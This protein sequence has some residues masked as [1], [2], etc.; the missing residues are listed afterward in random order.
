MGLCTAFEEEEYTV[1]GLMF[2]FHDLKRKYNF[3]KNV[4]FILVEFFCHLTFG[5][6]L[7][8]YHFA[9]EVKQASISLVVLYMFCDAMN[10]A[11][12]DKAKIVILLIFN[13]P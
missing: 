8:Q 3:C 7:Q 6:F 13:Q 10:A 11:V 9:P 4:I 12:K 5:Y 1:T 2:P